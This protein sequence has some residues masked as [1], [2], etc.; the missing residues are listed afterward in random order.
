LR[1]GNA[2]H[3]TLEKRLKAGKTLLIFLSLPQAHLQLAVGRRLLLEGHRKQ[4]RVEAVGG[5]TVPVG[6]IEDDETELETRSTSV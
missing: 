5:S 3:Q 1:N 6:Y 4:S 2:K